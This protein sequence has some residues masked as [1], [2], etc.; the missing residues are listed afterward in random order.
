[1]KK[2][3]PKL[4]TFKLP[5]NVKN[6]QTNFIHP[7]SNYL[8]TSQSI[9]PVLSESVDSSEANSI[10]NCGKVVWGLDLDDFDNSLA[11]NEIHS[12]Q[13]LE[14]FAKKEKNHTKSICIL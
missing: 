12:T 5:N 14:R 1:M 3:K 13:K 6:S 9:Y 11:F 2:S 4:T 8:Y 10:T 7:S